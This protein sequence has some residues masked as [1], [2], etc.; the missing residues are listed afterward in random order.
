MVSLLSLGSPRCRG[1]DEFRFERFVGGHADV[2][3]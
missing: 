2:G 1:Q 3:K